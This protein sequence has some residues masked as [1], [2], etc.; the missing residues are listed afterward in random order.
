[1]ASWKINVLDAL[2]FSY[3]A[4]VIKG[5]LISSR[6]PVDKLIWAKASNGKF[7]VKSAYGVAMRHSKSVDQ[8]ASSDQSH[9]RLF[10]KRI[11]DLPLPHKVRHFTW[12]ACKD[13]LLTK[14][15]LMR[16]NVVKDQFYDE[17]KVEAETVGHL[18]WMY[19]RAREAWSCSKIVVP[20]CHARVQSFQDMLLDMVVG[21]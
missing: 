11:W 3:K 6:L 4:D 19:P 2:F 17:C 8:G 20:S 9:L 12:Q 16:R 1:M 5:I 14:V 21:E 7:S 18:F 10:W 13:I 15:I